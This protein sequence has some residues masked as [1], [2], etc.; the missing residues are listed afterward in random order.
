MAKLGIT[1]IAFNIQNIKDENGLIENLGAD[2]TWKI[3]Q[4]AAITKAT[5]NKNIAQ[6]EAENEQLANEARVNSQKAIAQQNAD[7]AVEQANQKKRADTQ[8]A[9]ADAAYKIQEQDQQKIINEKTVEA[10]TARTLKEQELTLQKIQVTENQSSADKRKTEIDA[11]A[12]KSQTEINAKAELEKRKREAE[13]KRYEAEQEA[14]AI[15]AKADAKRYEMEQEAAGIRAKGDAEGAAIEAKLKGEAE[16]MK[17][18]AEA[19]KQYN[20]AALTQMVVDQLPEIT[21]NIASQVGA[22]DGINIYSNGGDSAGIGS[23]VGAAPM[24]LARANDTIKSAV[25]VDIA[26]LI[27][28]KRGEQK[29]APATKGEKKEDPKPNPTKGETKE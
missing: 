19:W 12:L 26:G 15:R 16:G 8:Q 28:G 7:L 11:E 22:I 20:D 23:I 17:E 4:D 6:A 3:R 10:S 27:N 5:A 2:N 29:P 9:I 14:E 21:K 13:A 18:K 1:I 25:G 24:I